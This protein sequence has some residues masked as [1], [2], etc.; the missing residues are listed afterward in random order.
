MWQYFDYDSSI[1]A[2]VQ[3]TNV[4]TYL[5]SGTKYFRNIVQLHDVVEWYQNERTNFAHIAR[6]NGFNKF[7]TLC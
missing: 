4:K 3:Y 6:C 7:D 1:S 2:L 5:H